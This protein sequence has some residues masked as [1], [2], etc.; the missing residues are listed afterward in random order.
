MKIVIAI[1]LV[2]PFGLFSN[3]RTDK[4]LEIGNFFISHYKRDFLNSSF[5]NYVVHQ[6]KDG[7][8]YV[9]NV[10]KGFIEFDG[11]RVRRVLQNGKPLNAFIRDAESD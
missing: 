3:N 1:L 9:G 4:D 11:Q 2:L 6:D 7:V 10:R 5:G 8:I